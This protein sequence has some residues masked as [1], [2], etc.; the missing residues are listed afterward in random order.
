M[1]RPVNLLARRRVVAIS[2]GSLCGMDRRHPIAAGID[3]QAC[4]QAQR[5]RA[6]RQRALLVF[7]ELIKLCATKWLIAFEG[8][9]L[10]AAVAYV[11]VTALPTITVMHAERT[12]IVRVNRF[13]ILKLLYSGIP[14]MNAEP[15]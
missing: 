14:Q 1:R 2:L 3:D 6:D 11:A 12:G 4:Q 9:S 15:A 5:L 8:G 10:D 7:V 13:F